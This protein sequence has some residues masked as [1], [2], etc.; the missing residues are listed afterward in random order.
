MPSHVKTELVESVPNTSVNSGKPVPI[1]LPK[2]NCPYVFDAMPTHDSRL[3]SDVGS[4]TAPLFAVKPFSRLNS[5]RHPPPRSSR[6]KKPSFEV[7][8]PPLCVWTSDF[9]PTV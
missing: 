3:K 4:C 8:S 9:P 1:C 6:P 5:A 2:R 7:H